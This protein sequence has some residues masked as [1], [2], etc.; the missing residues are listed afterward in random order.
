MRALGAGLV[1]F[2]I[3]FAVG[4]VLGTIR[5]VFVT[6][7]FGALTAVL[8]ELPFILTASWFVC[9]WVLRQFGLPAVFAARAVMGVSAFILLILAEYALAAAFQGQ[10]VITFVCALATLD[11]ATGFAG[12]IL[13]ALFPVV[14][15]DKSSI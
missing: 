5:T 7:H 9:R 11:G 8:I 14:Q 1:Y 4:F 12:Q 6:P 2:A 10:S 3:V 13:F 15:R